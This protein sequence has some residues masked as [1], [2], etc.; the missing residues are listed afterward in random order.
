M[1]ATSG[2][3]LSESSRRLDPLGSWV[4]MC[5][6]SLRWF[7]PARRL[8]WVA[9]TIFSRRE[10]YTERNKDM[11]STASVRTSRMRDI[12]SSRVLF[13]LVPSERRTGGTGYGLWRGGKMTDLLKTPSAMDAEIGPPKSNPKSGDSGCLAQEIVGGYAVILPTPNAV[14]AEKFAKT[15]NPDSQMGSSLT[16]MAV[17]DLLP[18]PLAV[19]VRH[20]KRCQE[21]RSAGD[22]PFHSRVNGETRPN[23]LE[24][25]LEFNG[26]MPS[27]V[28][29]DYRRRGPNSRQ[30]GL[31][32]LC[33]KLM[34]TPT[35]MDSSEATARMRSS[36]M[37]EG[38]MHSV[39]LARAV[40]SRDSK[41]GKTSQLNP[42]V[43]RGDDGI[44]FGV[45]DLA[46]PFGKWRKEAIKALGNAWVPEVAYE[47][48]RMIQ[49]VEYG[50]DNKGQSALLL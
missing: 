32:E 4:R 47:I 14:E 10:T 28:S 45:A 36:Q 46:L 7:S 12:P 40:Q 15:Y 21:L 50:Y 41:D 39:T 34:P 37:K 16:A 8:T 9:Q 20:S 27:P 42:P 5:L 49:E 19:S 23:G 38:S 18:T 43:C 1:T 17:N 26:L 44:P 3:R 31:P 22:V 25:Y 35:A 30:Q 11:S 2:R 48:F 24:D 33:H 13:R 6:E 29:Q